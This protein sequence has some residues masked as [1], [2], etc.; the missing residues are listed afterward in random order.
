MKDLSIIVVN[1]HT[2]DQ[3]MELVPFLLDELREMDGELIVIENGSDQV[4]D[5]FGPLNHPAVKLLVSPCNLGFARACNEGYRYA[6][7]AYVLLLNSDCFPCPGSIKRQWE[8]MKH[9]PRCGA[10]GMSLMDEQGEYQRFQYGALPGFGYL[11][12]R[13]LKWW[14]LRQDMHSW[15]VKSPRN[16]GWVSGAAL[17]INR[18]AIKGNRLL[19]DRFFMYFEDVELG[20]RLHRS[21][22]Q[23]HILPQARAVHRRHSNCGNERLRICHYK[24][25]RIRFLRG[26]LW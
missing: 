20:L 14:C 13:R 12:M 26:I 15:R 23:V 24:T 18:L 22:W 10:C 6:S 11:F 19:S 2:R 8:Y 17:M 16:V 7:G 3:L 9:H 1:Y 5:R 25:S 4:R 21:G